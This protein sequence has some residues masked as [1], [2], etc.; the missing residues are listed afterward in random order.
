MV[1]YGKF[2]LLAN[3]A[4]S[5]YLVGC[6]WAHEIDIFRSWQLLDLEAFRSGADGPMAQV[7]ILDFRAAG[8]CVP[9]VTRTHLET[10]GGSPTWAICRNLALLLLSFFLTAFMWGRWQ[11]RLSVDPLGSG[12]PYLK[13]ILQT[14]WM[15]TALINAYAPVL[16]LSTL[17][18]L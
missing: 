9:R 4:V 10:S 14:H 7:A 1:D 17:L 12:S 15:R 13:K 3:L 5:F 8:T 6:I 11:A 16:F 18:V 2:L